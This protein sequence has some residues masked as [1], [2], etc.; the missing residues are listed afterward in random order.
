MC[1]SDY[2]ADLDGYDSDQHGGNDCDD[3]NINVY[4]GAIDTF[5]YDGIDSDCFGNRTTTRTMMVMTATSMVE[6]I[7]MTA[8]V[9]F[10]PPRVSNGMIC[11]D[12]DCSGG[13]DYDADLMVES[14]QYGGLDCDDTEPQAPIGPASSGM[15]A[16]IKTVMAALI[17]MPTS[18]V[19]RAINMATTATIGYSRFRRVG[20]MYGTTG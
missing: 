11:F 15:M 1:R 19:M 20:L 17:T 10:R 16:S 9:P 13:S 6:T 12:Q 18:M 7:A 2:D 4:V 14:D 3:S 8:T 5:K